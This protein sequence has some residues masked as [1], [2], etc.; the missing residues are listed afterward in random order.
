VRLAPEIG[1]GPG[2][3]SERSGRVAALVQ[4]LVADGVISASA[5]RNELQDVRPMTTGFMSGPAAPSPLLR[6]ERAAMIYFGVPSFGVHLNGYVRDAMSGRPAAVWVAKRSMSK[7]T[8][9]GLLDQMVAGGQPAGM[10]F[11]ENIRKESEEEAS[12]PPDVVRQIVPTG[13]VSYKYSTR[14]GLSTK[15]LATFDV[16]MPDDMSPICSDGEV[17][18]FTLMPIDEV[19]A[20]IRDKLPIWKPNSALIMLDFAVRHGFVTP[21]EPGYAE[22]N[23]LLRGGLSS[24]QLRRLF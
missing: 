12:L 18:E 7:A 11:Q 2:S 9:P 3:E 4:E 19:L 14:K 13:L 10:S 24:D 17:E 20:S 22:L 6:L 15:V 1:M 23:H 8:Y 5:L 16:A 21:D